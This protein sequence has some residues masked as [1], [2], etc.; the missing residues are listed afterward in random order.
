MQKLTD[1]EKLIQ[2]L[3]LPKGATIEDTLEHDH[4]TEYVIRHP[5]P[6]ER[7][8]PHCGCT[9]CVKKDSRLQTV[10]H[11]PVTRKGTL[12]SFHRRRYR[13]KQCHASFN[14][15][16]YWIYEG[17]HISSALYISICMELQS[18]KSIRQIALDLAVSEAVVRGVL[19]A[20]PFGPAPYLPE[21]LC[22]DEFGGH[23]GIWDPEKKRW[24]TED[25]HCIIADGN[26]H[27]RVILDIL[28]KPNKD[29]LVRYF[30]TCF[31][32]QDRQRVKYFCCD[33]RPGF[34]STAAE[35]FKNAHICLD[36][37]HVVKQQTDRIRK[38]HNSV[39][40]RLLAEE[41]DKEKKKCITKT[42]YKA[43]HLLTARR[44]APFGYWFNDPEKKQE[45]LDKILALDEELSE[46]YQALQQFYDIIHSD[47]Y[48]HQ[49]FFLS[50]W[51]STY[52]LSVYEGMKKIANL[53][54]WNKTYILNTFKYGKSNSACEGLNANIKL[55]KK[56]GYGAHK[57]I[58]FRKR[59]LFAF[60]SI[61]FVQETYTIF[62][63]RKATARKG[64]AL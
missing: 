33:F 54:K 62:A 27:N 55:M 11:I 28:P 3:Q 8:C 19:E 56:N 60:G 6:S 26:P 21:T 22:I 58:T 37:F 7:V 9:D 32:E 4:L 20:I 30:K 53:Y 5:E 24:I 36:T 51:I 23:T 16:V 40:K 2:I 1:K 61:R 50:E 34:R 29:F 14:E 17:A 49:R 43:Q 18:T 46:A 39:K 41:P 57:F 38:L 63:E 47:S 48:A 59:L 52:F 12:I 31:T 25:F 64:E 42:F 15:P 44:N 35:C 45:R 13:C 10:R